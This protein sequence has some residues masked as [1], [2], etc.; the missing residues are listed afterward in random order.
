MTTQTRVAPFKRT[1]HIGTLDTGYAMRANV[2]VDIEWTGERLSMSGTAERPRA[3]DIDEGGQMQDTITEIPATDLLVSASARDQLVDIW[4]RWHL[5]DMRAGCEHQRAAGWTPARYGTPE[6]G[7]DDPIGKPCPMCGYRYGSAWLHE[8]VPADIL[9]IL[10]T[11]PE[12]V[13]A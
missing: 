11:W 7:T 12:E 13:S 1:V 5:N 9:Q 10:R 3:R 2:T 8:D 6:Y 4:N